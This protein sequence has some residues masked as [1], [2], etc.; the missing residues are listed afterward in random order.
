MVR[1]FRYR[2]YPTRAQDERMRWTLE[3]LRELYNAALEERREAYRRQGESL[4]GYDQMAELKAVRDVRPEYAGIP[5]HLMQD[6][7]ARLDRAYRGFF[8]RVKAGESPGFPRFRGFGRYTSFR[9][10]DCGPKGKKHWLGA[11]GRRLSLTGIGDVKIKLHRP[12]EGRLKQVTITLDGDGHWY[13]CM[14]CDEVPAKPLPP[15]GESVGI[16]V[17]ITTLAALSNG[18][19]VA[20]PRHHER[21]QA[22]LARVQRTV[23]RRKN[24]RSNRRR[25]TVALLRLACARVRRQRLDHHHK[26]VV[27]LVRRF[28]RIAVEDL[29]IKG[30]ARMRLAKQVND[31]AWG[32][33]ISILANKAECAGRELIKV[34]PSGTSQICSECGAEV[35][36][37]LSVRVHDCPHCGYVADRDHNAARNVEQRAGLAR[38]GGE[39]GLAVEPRSRGA[40]TGP[41]SCHIIGTGET[42]S[43]AVEE[44]RKQI[45]IWEHNQREEW[46][47]P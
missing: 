39:H 38:R 19:Q 9:F 44:A 25:K 14:C 13:A 6:A 28:D 12:I 29:N 23:S 20:N 34:N 35:R 10:K 42:E 24:K 40:S 41:R 3:R 45:R 8:R 16:D 47:K 33:F 30:L 26:V 5:T 15:T 43:E 22:R 4:S 32:Q 1:V 18:E 27:G 46:T 31:A 37:D 17:G 11:G 7:I 36:K 21:A 2:L